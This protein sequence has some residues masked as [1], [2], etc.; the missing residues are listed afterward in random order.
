MFTFLISTLIIYLLISPFIVYEEM[1]ISFSKSFLIGVL[2]NKD[3]IE[4]EEVYEHTAQFSFICIIVT[5]I[6]LSTD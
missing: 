3:Y 6:W 1:I 2:Y 5:Y 4:D